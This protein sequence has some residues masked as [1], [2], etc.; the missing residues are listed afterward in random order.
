MRDEGGRTKDRSE[1]VSVRDQ[2]R[3]RVQDV[4]SFGCDSVYG[5]N[6]PSTFLSTSI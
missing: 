4:R 5:Y 1:R 2:C 3:N 6:I